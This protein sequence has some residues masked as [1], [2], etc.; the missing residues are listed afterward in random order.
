[1]IGKTRKS[2]REEHAGQA[3]EEPRSVLLGFRIV[4][5][6]DESQTSGCPL[7]ELEAT[8]G[9]AGEYLDRLKQFV[10]ER[11]IALEYDAKIAPAQGIFYGGKIALLPGLTEAETFS[12]LAHE[13]GHELIHKT[14]RRTSVT[15]TI[16]ETEAEAVAFV[17]CKA[18]GLNPASSAS[19]IQLYHGNAELLMESLEMVQRTAAVILAAI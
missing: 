9:E 14:S 19:Y 7:R 11:G 17:V 13:L 10:A 15:K 16:R 8:T 12:V 5:V 18:I 2:T 1:M 3:Q 6:F 4:H